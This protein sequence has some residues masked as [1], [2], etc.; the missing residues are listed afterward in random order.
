MSLNKTAEVSFEYLAF[1]LYV[2][3]Y[4]P[5]GERFSKKIKNMGIIWEIKRSL[6]FKHLQGYEGK[7]SGQCWNIGKPEN[8]YLLMFC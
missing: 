4:L 8:Y 1:F 5:S 6:I 7:L 2:G 3:S